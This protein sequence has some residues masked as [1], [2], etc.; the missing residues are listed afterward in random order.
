M[1]SQI[2]VNPR[3]HRGTKIGNG[4]PV[5]AAK[6][7]PGGTSFGGGPIFSLQ[8]YYGDITEEPMLILIWLWGKISIENYKLVSDICV[9]LLIERLLMH[10]GGTIKNV[11]RHISTYI[12][13]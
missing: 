1:H 13:M 5:L 9:M 8:F 3:F 7:G 11:P 6:I 2:V 12:R 10:N 4:R